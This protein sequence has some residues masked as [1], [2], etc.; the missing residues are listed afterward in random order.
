MDTKFFTNK[1]RPHCVIVGGGVAGLSAAC[2]LTNMGWRI[3]LLEKRPFLGGRAYSFLDPIMGTE[4][5]NGQHVFLGCCSEYI[6]LIDTLGGLNDVYIQ[7]SLRVPIVLR[8]KSSSIYSVNL[9]PAP[10]NLLPSLI[11][12]KHLALSDKARI[13]TAL[14]KI[15][16]VNIKKNKNYLENMT[17]DK[18]LSENYQKTSS[19]MP[20]W[21]LIIK[22]TL[23]S[24]CEKVSAYMGT[25][26]FKEGF[27]HY[28][29]GGNIGYSKIGLSNL[30]SK[31]I[32]QI[33]STTGGEILTNA[34]VSG[35][36]TDNELATGVS[37]R[38]TN[39]HSVHKIE[40]NAVISAVPWD[41]INLI[42]PQS[43]SMETKKAF[44]TPALTHGSIITLHIWLNKPVM[45]SDFIAVLGSEL[46]W[47]FNKTKM[48][49]SASNGQQ[50]TI[51]ISDAEKY[52]SWSKKTL[53]NFFIEELIKSFPSINETN[54]V[55]FLLIKHPQATFI[56]KP[57]V[58]NIRYP[59]K[60]SFKNLYFAGDWTNTDWPSTMESAVI[61]GRL[62]AQ[63]LN[64]LIMETK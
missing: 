53:R 47:I 19:I 33:L 54:I 16:F 58:E 63:Q 3:T 9:L 34:E 23:N 24:S 38:N 64:N 11:T 26:I 44:C 27:L 10:L 25:R 45:D 17:F 43:N 59:Q 29:N 2:H 7:T 30:I 41:K 62:A 18:W 57:G 39:K 15:F 1:K 52:I 50:L 12:Y 32:H 4:I 49:E 51:S 31:N 61:S 56:S 36:L 14:S 37:L 8:E 20:F 5:D 40:S 22:A 55:R 35:I 13:F 6:N 60:T 21:D 42:A 48:H 28:K 46:Q